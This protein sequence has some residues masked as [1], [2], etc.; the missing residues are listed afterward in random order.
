ML[1]ASHRMRRSVD[2]TTA[3]RRGRRAGSPTLVVHLVVTNQ[4]VPPQVG[5]VVS[6]AVGG[7]TVRNAVR[8]RLR[9]LVR[10]QLAALP[11]GTLLVVRALPSAAKATGDQLGRDLS[12]AL[13]VVLARPP[14]VVAESV[15]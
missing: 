1:P 10:E 12:A 5:F 13:D 11:G 9:H 3:V 2:F 14:R 4:D 8:R 7:A 15:R 6:R